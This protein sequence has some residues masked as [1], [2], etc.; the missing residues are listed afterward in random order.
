MQ[1]SVRG[2]LVKPTHGKERDVWGTQEIAVM[3]IE[4][5]RPRAV[6]RDQGVPGEE[7]E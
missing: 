1:S 2:W 6:G 7:A 5:R 3:G 4:Q